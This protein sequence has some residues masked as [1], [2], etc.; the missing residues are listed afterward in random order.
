MT[1]DGLRELLAAAEE[2]YRLLLEEATVLLRNFD[3][4]DADDFDRAVAR[5]QEILDAIQ[6]N[7][8]C[9]AAL[10][11][12]AA[13]GADTDVEALLGSF[14]LLRE[15]TTRKVLELD[16]LVTALA[17]ERL[18]RIQGEM[19]ALAKGKVAL[20]GYEGSGREKRHQLNSTA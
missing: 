16:A 13:H 14:R 2:Q 17:Q 19:A 4:S 8:E 5:R 20:H 6:K 11:G 1:S 15:E 12:G 3:S 9:M 10:S 18:G 7:D